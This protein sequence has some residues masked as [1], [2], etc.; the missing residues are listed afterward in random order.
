MTALGWG[1]AV[2][3]AAPRCQGPPIAGPK[4][5][6]LA[7]RPVH[8]TH[9]DQAQTSPPHLPRSAKAAS[10]PALSGNAGSHALTY[11]P[12]VEVAV[13]ER[14]CDSRTTLLSA[15]VVATSV[16]LA[17]TGGV[18]IAVSH[19]SAG[20]S[21]LSSAIAVF[22]LWLFVLLLAYSRHRRWREAAEVKTREMN[23]ERARSE[24]AI[25]RIAAASTRPA[26]VPS[27]VHRLVNAMAR[28]QSRS[29]QSKTQQRR[30]AA[31]PHTP[32]PPL[33]RALCCPSPHE[34]A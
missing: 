15:A 14:F 2:A 32:S 4:S 18:L 1:A 19:A 5:Q 12:T 3:R 28:P 23:Q 13:P 24:A 30:C 11:A 6:S 25:R 31:Q 16:V 34:G 27:R 10:K 8:R 29:T 20:A 33:S 22:V 21:V 9:G 7:G 26:P 17:V